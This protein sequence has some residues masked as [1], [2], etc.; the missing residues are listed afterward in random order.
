MLNPVERVL[1]NPYE[2]CS[3]VEKIQKW[4]HKGESI[5]EISHQRIEIPSRIFLT[6]DCRVYDVYRLAIMIF[7]SIDQKVELSPKDLHRFLKVFHLND[8][9]YE[10]ILKDAEM[11]ARNQVED[12]SGHAGPLEFPSKLQIARS[13]LNLFACTIPSGQCQI[14]KNYVVAPLIPSKEFQRF[15]T[16][17]YWADF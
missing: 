9:K 8:K 17:N 10:E 6:E 15:H 11:Y 7:G 12:A 4:R 14:L 16:D 2:K 3:F 13:R 5:C 1:K